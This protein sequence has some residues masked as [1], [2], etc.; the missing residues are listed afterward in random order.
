MDKDFNSRF[1]NINNKNMLKK[2]ERTVNAVRICPMSAL[3]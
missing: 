3:R 1:I 2:G